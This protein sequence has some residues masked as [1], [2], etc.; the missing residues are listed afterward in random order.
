[1]SLGSR[2]REFRNK[3]GL[4]QGQLADKLEMTEANIS[5][6]ERDKSAPPSDKLNAIA[7][8][9]DV[10]TDYLLGRTSNPNERPEHPD[11]DDNKDL[12]FIAREY[13]HLDTAQKDLLMTMLKTMRKDRNQ[14]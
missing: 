9:L 4:T 7:A 10:S 1:M 13:K 5:S 8:I 2:I 3:R 6:Y 14:K 12:H 11:S